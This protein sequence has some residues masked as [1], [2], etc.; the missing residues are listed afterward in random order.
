MKKPSVLMTDFLEFF[1][2]ELY[3]GGKQ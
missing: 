3:T 2:L 1:N